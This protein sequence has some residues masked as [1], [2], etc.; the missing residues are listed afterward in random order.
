MPSLRRKDQLA[1]LKGID[2]HQPVEKVRLVPGDVVTAYRKHNEDPFK[3]FYTKPGNSV[4]RLGVNPEPGGTARG[5][6][7]RPWR[8]A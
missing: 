8:S 7:S 2:L 1:F 3:T 5:A 4:H 6:P